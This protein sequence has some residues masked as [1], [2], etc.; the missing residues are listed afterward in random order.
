MRLIKFDYN[1]NKMT[2]TSAVGYGLFRGLKIIFPKSQISVKIHLEALQQPE[3]SH[4]KSLN[5]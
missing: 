3:H 4:A 2:P 5:S 1:C